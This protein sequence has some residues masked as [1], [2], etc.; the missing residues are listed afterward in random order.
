MHDWVK[1]EMTEDNVLEIQGGHHPLQALQV[2]TFVPNDTHI[3]GGRG[4]GIEPENGEDGARSV[5]I[6]TGA[7]ACGK[8]VYL[9]QNALIPFMAQIGC[10]VPAQSARLGVVDKI[11]TR[12]QTQEGVSKLQ[13]SFMIDLAQVSLALRNST[14]RSL[15]VMDEFG[16]G[17][18]STDGAGL[19]AGVISH[20]LKRG[21]E[22]PKVLAS[23]HF[24]ELFTRGL[25]PPSFPISY[26]YMNVLLTE[27]H[28]VEG[29]GL[30]QTE[31]TYLYKV[32]PGLC[33]ESY[34][35]ECARS[36]GLRPDIV[37]RA[38]FV[39][40]ILKRDEIGLLLDEDMT[41]EEAKELE[42]CAEVCQRFVRW[43]MSVQDEVKVKDRLDAVLGR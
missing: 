4:I 20:L 5:V 7:N 36:Y 24:H 3:A 1:P 38:R 31:V 21:A 32:T 41:E 16:K 33:L 9:K 42:V 35:A 27:N 6:V 25:I 40:D 43:K 13:S 11:F 39:S 18:L 8:S 30:S 12:V 34:A 37:E 17:S 15:I 22:C 28:N 10:F 19:F 23:T 29:G 26:A 2:P 14:A